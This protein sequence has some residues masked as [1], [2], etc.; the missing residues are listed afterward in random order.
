MEIWFIFY[1]FYK[2]ISFKYI[3]KSNIKKLLIPVT[4][5]IFI[6]VK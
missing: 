6:I 5:P 4:A 3:F 2:R 1:I